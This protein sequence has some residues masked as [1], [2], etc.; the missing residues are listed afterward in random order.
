MLIKGFY[1]NIF[2]KCVSVRKGIGLV[3]HPHQTVFLKTPLFFQHPEI[4]KQ[5]KCQMY[6]I[7][8]RW[9]NDLTRRDSG[10][11]MFPIS[12][13]WIEGR[14]TS[15]N[16]THPAEKSNNGSCDGKTASAMHFL[17]IFDD[18]FMILQDFFLKFWKSMW[19]ILELLTQISSSYSKLHTKARC[20]NI[21]R[22]FQLVIIQIFNIY[23]PNFSIKQPRRKFVPDSPDLKPACTGTKCAILAYCNEEPNFQI[24][25]N[26]F[27]TSHSRAI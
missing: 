27:S 11:L 14:E 6:K 13:S 15:L 10:I 7:T 21:L 2:Q 19:I 23:L 24:F 18:E 1:H 26:V 9:L 22:Y 25:R 8:L 20:H 16:K 3:R 5:Q 17:S 12:S 4:S